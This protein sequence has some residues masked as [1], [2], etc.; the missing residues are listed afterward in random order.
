VKSRLQMTTIELNGIRIEHDGGDEIS[1]H[2]EAP[3]AI[4]IEDLIGELKTLLNQTSRGFETCSHSSQSRY[5][6]PEESYQIVE[7]G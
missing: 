2:A 3:S 5:S 7:P 4:K 6:P 1:I